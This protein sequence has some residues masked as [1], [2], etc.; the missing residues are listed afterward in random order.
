[1][2]LILRLIITQSTLLFKITIHNWNC[3][4]LHYHIVL[5]YDGHNS[6]SYGISILWGNFIF[7]HVVALTVVRRL[8]IN[9]MAHIISRMFSIALFIFIHYKVIKIL[10]YQN[11][12][13]CFS[14]KHGLHNFPLVNDFYLFWESRK[15]IEISVISGHQII[16]YSSYG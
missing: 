14:L 16:K 12:P 8:Y 3:W 1:M 10:W 2:S 6:C 15:K 9:H 4:T 5:L 11:V 13:V 7:W